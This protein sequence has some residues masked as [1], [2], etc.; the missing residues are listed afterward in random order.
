MGNSSLN[1]PIILGFNGSHDGSAALL[2]GSHLLGTVSSERVSRQKKKSNGN[3]E[4]TVIPLLESNGLSVDNIDYVSFCDNYNDPEN[5]FIK[6][7]DSDGVIRPKSNIYSRQYEKVETHKECHALL[8]DRKIPAYFV[9]HHLG[10]IAYSYFTSG[11]MES[12]CLSLDGSPHN[13]SLLA[14]AKGNKFEILESN[15]LSVSLLYDW[16][17]YYVLGNPLYKA[18]SMMGLA[19]YGKRR[20]FIEWQGQEGNHYSKLFKEI[21]NR[22]AF[23]VNEEAP[24]VGQ[25]EADLAG[26]LQLT[27][28]EE[29]LKYL[30]EALEKYNIGGYEKICL[31]GGSFLNCKF[32]GRLR[33]EKLFDSIHLAPACGDDGLSVGSALYV[34]HAVLGI[35]PKLWS[36]SELA[37]SGPS[38]S[39]PLAKGRSFDPSFLAREISK[40]KIVALFQGRSEFGPRALGNR[41]ILADPRDPKMR[42]YLNQRV[43]KRE[44]FR[45]YG[46]SVCFE[47]QWNWFDLYEESPFMLEAVRCKKPEKVP[48]I[49]HEDGT[50]R[51]QSVRKELNPLFY[52]VIKEFGNLTSTPLLLNT[53]LND[54]S[55]PMVE[56]PEDA[57]YF[58]KNSLIDILVIEGQI[59]EKDDL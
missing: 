9:N 52:Q 21:M 34:A 3:S 31:S 50:S 13:Y 49:V 47:D 2:R 22:P 26:R 54:S 15:K 41:S 5:A 56:K 42:D 40:G 48:A 10:H 11:F 36:S 12:L 35:N 6:I 19:A 44:W 18:G 55:E 39:N 27:F 32:N 38:Y 45:P 33:D 43:K 28:E 24:E 46:A 23:K 16:F 51:I 59:Y 14:R 58:F 17:T 1:E 8:E 25:E 30:Q 53:S 57:I 7:I 4:E 37:Y 29:I 20:D